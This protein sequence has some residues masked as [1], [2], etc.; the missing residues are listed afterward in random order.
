MYDTIRKL[1]KRDDG[2][3]PVIGTILMVAVTVVLGATVYAALSGFGSNAVQESTNAVFKAVAVDTDG[4]G[5]TDTL[6]ITY[7]TGPSN[8]A[9]GDISVNLNPA[10]TP[11]WTRSSPG[12]ATAVPP[13]EATWNPG[14]FGTL[15]P[16]VATT[17][18]VS[19]TV[20]GTTVLDQSVR[21]DE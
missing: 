18:F 16:G 6:K 14:D 2:V 13:V 20:L 3:S 10:D 7:V 21:L 8:V 19:V 9:L 4:N 17:Y 5:R 11:T 15:S 1:C 12:D